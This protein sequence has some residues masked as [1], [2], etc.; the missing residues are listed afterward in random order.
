[1]AQKTVQ[2]KVYGAWLYRGI[3]DGVTPPPGDNWKLITMRP[4]RYKEP[5]AGMEPKSGQVLLLMQG[6]GCLVVTPN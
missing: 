1:M 3:W 5:P 4:G 6:V 2:M